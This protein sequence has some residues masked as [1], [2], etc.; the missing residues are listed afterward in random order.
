MTRE[1]LEKEC[2]R[3]QKEIDFIN[4]YFRECL[5]KENPSLTEK[6]LKDIW[7]IKMEKN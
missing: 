5:R 7:V 4:N 2:E 3:Q 6:E 1:D